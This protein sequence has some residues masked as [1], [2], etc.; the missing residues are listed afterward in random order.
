MKRLCLLILL[1]VFAGFTSARAQVLMRGDIDWWTYGDR[2]YMEVEKIT[3]F[4][5]TPTGELRLRLVATLNHYQEWRTGFTLGRRA[6][7]P[8]A[9]NENRIGIRRKARLHLPDRADWYFI[10]LVLE[11]R[12]TNSDGTSSWETLDAVEFDDQAWLQDSWW[13]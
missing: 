4:N 10:T 2:L 12:V 1:T 5:D 6:I 11:E 9:E 13:W 7:K 3:N 8:L